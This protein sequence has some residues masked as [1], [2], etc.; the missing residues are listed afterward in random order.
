MTPSP[1]TTSPLPSFERPP[2]N[3]VVLGMQFA[4]P[5]LGVV[6]VGGLYKRLQANYSHIQQ[7]PPLQ[8]TFETFAPS[9]GPMALQISILPPF[10]RQ[11]FI[12]DDGERL[13][14][15]QADRLLA[16]WRQQTGGGPYPRYSKV[17]EV[18]LDALG[19]F[20]DLM[21]K[22]VQAAFSPNQCEVTYIN[23][24]DLTGPEEWGQPGRWLRLWNDEPEGSEVARFSTQHLIKDEFGQP[25]ARLTTTVEPGQAADRSVLQLSLSVR[26]RPQTPD[27][28]GVLAFCDMGRER[29]VR[30]F[31]SIT[32]DA[33]HKVWGEA[34]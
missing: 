29:I 12:A 17:R 11:W 16:N 22:D 8:V 32:T 13:I 15:F 4:A 6:H 21:Q 18:F 28:S 27:I 23:Q 5:E 31:A 30:R 2:V 3:E 9:P 7:V 19:A 24:I 25:Y 33:A 14:Q 34:A 1:E 10:P 20:E 26:G